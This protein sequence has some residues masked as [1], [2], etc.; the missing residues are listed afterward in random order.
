MTLTIQTI[1]P[2]IIV[3]AQSNTMATRHVIPKGTGKHEL[4]W[5]FFGYEDDD[6]DMRTRRVRQSNLM[7]AAG[8]VT[9]DDAEALEFSQIG[10]DGAA[11]EHTAVLDLGG[12]DAES[13]D[14][15][16]TE[17]M[18]RGFYHCYRQM[19]GYV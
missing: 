10:V 8:Y 4:I 13:G 6:E 16:V 12:R 2:S 1:F 9:L 19:M 18:I 15:L 17:G 5:T 14:H 11:P 3:Q 7:G